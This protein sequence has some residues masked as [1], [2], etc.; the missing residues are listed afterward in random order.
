GA[1]PGLADV[2]NGLLKVATAASGKS[3]LDLRRDVADRT[4]DDDAEQLV[5]PALQDPKQDPEGAAVTVEEEAIPVPDSRPAEDIPARPG[6]QRPD[7]TWLVDKIR[8][9]YARRSA[10]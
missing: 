2:R 8:R 5:P 10:L 4:F 7:V 6:D 9:Q 3:I 1:R